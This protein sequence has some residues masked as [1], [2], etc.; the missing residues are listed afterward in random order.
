MK[1]RICGGQGYVNL[2]IDS[3][4]ERRVDCIFCDGLG[5]D[6]NAKAEKQN[7]SDWEREWADYPRWNRGSS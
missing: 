6:K 4:E 7:Q 2:N 5:F 1:C 3:A